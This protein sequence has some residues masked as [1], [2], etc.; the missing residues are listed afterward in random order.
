[1]HHE[2]ELSDELRAHLES[3]MEKLAQQLGATGKFPEGKLTDNDE[4]E[5]AFAVT[6]YHGKVVVNFGKPIASLGMSPEQ[7]RG[8]ALLLR[9]NANA[10]ERTP[11]L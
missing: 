3:N 7:A 1:M 5:L 2:E 11:G 8:F 9:K 10:I 4:G 6:A